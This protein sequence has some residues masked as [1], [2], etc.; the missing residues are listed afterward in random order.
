V[1]LVQARTLI[2]EERLETGTH[3]ARKLRREGK[4]PGVCYGKKIGNIP[5]IISAKEIDNILTKEGENVILNVNLAGKGENSS[6]AAIIRNVQRHPLSKNTVHVDLH[7]ISLEE[8][9]RSVIPIVLDGEAKGV[10][11]GGILQHGLR[12]IEV[13]A[14]PAD[15]PDHIS[16]D[17]SE[18]GVGERLT[19][20]DIKVPGDVEILTEPGA[21]VATIVT[22]RVQEDEKP[23]EGTELETEAEVDAEGE[24][25]TS[26]EE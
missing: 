15:L 11:E 2:V 8:K 20:A 21:V 7:Q 3:N 5:V 1:G 22:V 12:E 13:E 23:A 4:I 6:F 24:T 9:I 17:I 10:K 25:G 19:V 26:A 14:L 16:V 18:L